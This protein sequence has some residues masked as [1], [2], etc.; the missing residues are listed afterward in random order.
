MSQNGLF[1][2]AL[3]SPLIPPINRGLKAGDF[4]SLNSVADAAKPF[5]ASL[6]S[7]I[8]NRPILAVTDGLKSQEAFFND[9]QTLLP[10]VQFYPAWETLPHE[11]K[12]P[13]ADTI[14]DRLKVLTNLNAPVTVASVQALMQRTFAPEYFMSLRMELRLGQ[15]L[16]LQQFLNKLTELGYHAEY[17]VSD[18][19]DMAMRGGIVDFFPIDREEP[20]RVE[21]SGDEIESIRTFDPITQQ[22]REKRERL[23]VTPAGELGLLKQA[24]DRTAPLVDLLP[25]NTLLVLDEPDKLAEAA[26]TYARQIPEGDKFFVE[27]RHTLESGLK[28]VQLTEAMAIAP[29]QSYINLR[30][31]SLDAFRPLDTRSPE[32]EVAEQMRRSFFEQMQRWVE[33]GYAL[34]VFCSTDGE[35]QRFEELW[36]EQYKA[37]PP[38]LTIHPSSFLSRGFLW[39]DAK[40]A[41]VT[42][43][44]IFGRYKLVRPRRKFHQ[45]AQAADWTELQEGDFVVHVQHGIGKYLGLK[46]LDFNGTKQEVLS[47][48]YADEA[49]LYVPID[50]AHLV[51]KYVGAGKRQPPLHQLGGALWQ[52]QKLSAERA[53]MDLAANLLEIQAARNILEGHA[54]SPD[55]AWQHEFEAAFVYDETPDQLT[56]IEE[57]K[58]DMESSRP[59]DRLICGDVGYGKTEVAIR[60]A[61]KAVMDGYQ[62]AVLCPTTV[63]AEQH[64]NTF[65][66]RM[67]G[68]PVA[69]EMLSRF[70]TAREQKKV[71]QLLR[72]GGVDIVIGTHRLLSGDILFKNL[73]L[74]VVDEEQ[75]F[76]VLHKERFKQLRKLV[77]VVTLSATPIPRT[78]YLSLTGARD[79][80]NIQTPPQDRLPVETIIAGYDERLIKQ[81]IQRELNRG[82]QVYF[83]HNR[84]QSIEAV[85]AR[86]RT[87]LEGSKI[88]IDVGHG[89]MS[90]DEL[91]DVMRRFVKGDIDVLVCTTIIESGLD[92]PNA[93]T[94]IIDRADRFGLSDLYQLR[95]RVGRYKHQA[96]AY[97]L[98]PRHMNLVQSARKRIGA[99]K[100]YSSLGS[101]F[102]IAMRDLEIRGA[103]NILGSEQSGHI[104]AIGFDLYCQLLK[105]SIARM[106]GEK[107]KHRT[108]VTLKL[109][110]LN[111]ELGE[112]YAR[113]PNNYISD[114][115]LRIQA[116]RKIALALE[117][118]D[119]KSFRREFRDRFGK[120]P[121]EVE[122]LFQCAEVRIQAGDAHIETVETREDRIMLSQRGI[123]FQVG[124]KFPR[125]TGATPE[126]KLA[127]I[128]GVLLSVTSV[129]EVNP[130]HVRAPNDG[131]KSNLGGMKR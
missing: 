88:R 99:I 117:L 110:F 33:E 82:G 89:Q 22:S 122:I 54:F 67:S 131:S 80:S 42:D 95:G 116:Y 109:D 101:G 120:I 21:F 102:K 87:L 60:A 107:P 37:L 86:L 118:A 94:I 44:E 36:R 55:T 19:G 56:A 115:R 50:Q 14:A 76:G 47:I 108:L 46:S 111:D 65:R 51:S 52:R 91:E 24:E 45:L 63:L 69:I 57:V 35:K 77:D 68:Y 12:L 98:L 130:K 85:A 15:T 48:E 4:L 96:Y 113:I 103:G 43:S 53:I 5:A 92:I 100:Q 25:R 32:P 129:V 71:A 34:H 18:P 29:P 9:L 83:L 23:V 126:E 123:L 61:F 84:V 104:T 127:E 90:D 70:R 16:E 31:A 64:W 75:R 58:R 11:D 66:E 124:G 8:S 81:A 128:K 38:T 41:V 93:N 13:Q 20:V 125:M 73:G 26:E 72:K 2:V 10:G 112:S 114:T 74:V 1:E 30:L 59:M 6:L 28:L 121:R 40:L 105:E 7:Q 27:W 79:M 106:K 3:G 119:V 17:Q 49:R 97:I 39:S 62:V 78:L